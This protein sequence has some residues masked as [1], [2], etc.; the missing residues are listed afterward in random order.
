MLNTQSQ[1]VLNLACLNRP[2][3]AAMEIGARIRQ[4]RLKNKLSQSNFGDICGVSKGMVSQWE[5]GQSTPTTEKLIQLQRKL[6]FS[7]D[8]LLLGKPEDYPTK[9]IAHVVHVMEHMDLNQQ[10]LVARLADQVAQ[11]KDKEVNGQ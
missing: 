5:S 6:N 10:Y 8:W 4:L 3:T 11:P 1:S 2:Y 7:L 9:P